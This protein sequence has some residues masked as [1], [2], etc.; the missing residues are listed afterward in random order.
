MMN[1]ACNYKVYYVRNWTWNM[2][3]SRREEKKKVKWA[4]KSVTTELPLDLH[5]S[6]VA[7][8]SIFT[9]PWVLIRCEDCDTLHSEPGRKEKR[10]AGEHSSIIQV[11]PQLLQS[12]ERRASHGNR[13]MPD[14]EAPTMQTLMREPFLLFCQ[15]HRR[16]EW[17]LA[18][19]DSS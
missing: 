6:S 9:K 12:P 10:A 5:T 18:P 14:K 1:G 8:G 15:C 11:T 4:K 17:G 3:G 13:S 2:K 7:P 16:L 19:L